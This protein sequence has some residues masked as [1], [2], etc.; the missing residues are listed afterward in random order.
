[1]ALFKQLLWIFRHY[2][3]FGSLAPVHGFQRLFSSEGIEVSEADVRVPM[4]V[5]KREHIRQLTLMPCI[6]QC[7]QTSKG[8]RITE[9]DINRLY[10]AFLSMQLAAIAENSTLIRGVLELVAWS[11]QQKIELGANTGYTTQMISGLVLSIAEQ[12]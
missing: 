1:M 12:G 4:G 6:A 7:W 10:A 2:R 3:Y 8:D 9:V 5:E 11:K